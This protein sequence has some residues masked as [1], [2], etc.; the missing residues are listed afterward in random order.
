MKWTDE[1]ERRVIQRLNR[2]R[3]SRER[4]QEPRLRDIIRPRDWFIAAGILLWCWVVA[5]V[6]LSLG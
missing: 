3:S 2:E 1:T 5:V 4:Y 6:L